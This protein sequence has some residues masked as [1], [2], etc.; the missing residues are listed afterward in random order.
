MPL[1]GNWIGQPLSIGKTENVACY[2]PVG[3]F[4]LSKS[5]VFLLLFSGV[6]YQGIL[7]SS[8]I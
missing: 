6:S 5:H 1:P 2:R 8:L 4:P 3:K 7:Y